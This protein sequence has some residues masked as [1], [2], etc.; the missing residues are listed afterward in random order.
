LLFCAQC[1]VTVFAADKQPITGWEA[2]SE[3]DRLYRPDQYVKLK[4][5]LV[6]IIEVVPKPGMVPGVGMV[7]HIRDGERATVHFAPKWFARFLIYGF[8]K[9]DNVKVKGCWAEIEGK[10]FF[11]ASKVRNGEVFEM[12]F[13]RT[14]DGKPYWTL[15]PEEMIKEKL[16]Q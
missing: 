3:Y 13:R 16:E 14:M 1:G 6:E 7:F 11:M 5:T 10:K 9:G 15:T 4:G 12:K 8:K 2:E